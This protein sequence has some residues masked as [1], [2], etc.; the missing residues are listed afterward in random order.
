M[1]NELNLSWS[2][3]LKFFIVAGAVLG[4]FYFRQILLIFLAALLLSTALEKLIKFWEKK[5]VPRIISTTVVYLGMLFVFGL[6]LYVIVPP[7]L[8]NVSTLINNLPTILKVEANSSFLKMLTPITQSQNL[9]ETFLSNSYSLDGVI[10]NFSALFGGIADFLLIFL[11]AFYLSLEKSWFKNLLELFLPSRYKK[12]FLGLW[13]K[14]EDKMV[15]WLYSQI[16]LSVFLTSL[17]IIVFYILGI[18]YPLLLAVLMGVFD[19]VPFI[20]AALSTIIIVLMNLSGGLSQIILLLCICVGLQYVQNLI[21]PYVRSR[22]L[23]IDP[24]ITLFFMAILGKFGG[25]LGVFIA[26]PLSTIIV[27]FAKD[28]KAH[29]VCQLESDE[30]SENC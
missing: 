19:F 28:L 2:S 27:E 11:I 18:E 16:I 24:I 20:G 21:A 25:I 30:F 23:K 1:N 10:K 14:S 17:A 26:V 3:L 15:Y 12:Y 4:L 13:K 6:T 8:Q 5:H 29:K 22:F 9:I 7:F